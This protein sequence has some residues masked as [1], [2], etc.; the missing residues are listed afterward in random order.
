[1]P[2]RKTRL[3]LVSSLFLLSTACGGGGGADDNRITAAVQ[4]LAVS[5]DG[6]ATVLTFKRAP[7]GLTTA[8]FEAD[9]GQDATLVVQVGRIATVHWSERVTPQH[10]VRVVGRSG[11]RSGYSSVTTTDASVPIFTIPSALQGVGLGND[12]LTVQF[13]GPRVVETL[14]EDPGSWQLEVNGE[15]MDLTGTTFVLD[16][17]S[18]ELTI[19]TGP[20]ANVHAVFELKATGVTSVADVPLAA[21]PV[22]GT[23]TGDTSAPSL[24]SAV[25][26]LAADAYGRSVDFT[27]DEAMDPVFSPLLPNFGGVGPDLATSVTQTS[28]EVFRVT[29]NNP[30]VPGLDVVNLTGLMDAHGNA[31][32]PVSPTVAQGATAANA[33]DPAPTVATVANLGGDLVT[34][35]FEQALDPD[36]ADLEASWVLEVPTGNVL[37]LSGATFT[38]DLLTR[39]LA[40]ELAQDLQTGDTFTFGPSGTP[41][42]DVDGQDFADV[43][44]GFVGGDALPPSIVSVTQNRNVDPTG[45]TLDV[46]FSEDVDI[47]LATFDV[48]G[49]VLNTTTLLAGLET[50]RLTFTTAPVPGDDTLTVLDV[51]DLA[52]TQSVP[53]AGVTITSSD[54]SA[55]QAISSSALAVEGAAND[56]VVV[57][58]DDTLIAAEVTDPDNWVFQSPVG[59]SIDLSTAGMNWN[60]NAKLVRVTLPSGLNLSRGDDYSVQFSGMRDIGGNTITSAVLSGV[61]TGEQNLP[62]VDAVWVESAFTNELHVR[63]S[64]PCSYLDDILGFT[65]YTLRDSLGNLKSVPAVASPHADLMG[66]ELIFGVFVNAGSDT[67]DIRGVTDLAGNVLF[68]VF[69]QPIEV[70]DPLPP[71]FSIGSSTFTTQSGEDNDQIEIVFDRR[72]SSWRLLVPSRYQIEQAGNPLDLDDATFT[73]D[74]AFMVTI[75]LDAP[76]TPALV[77]GATYD[78]TMTSLVSAQG[79]L[80]AGPLGDSLIAAG[81]AV[82][83]ALGAGGARIDP[84]DPNA[85]IVEFDEALLPDDVVTPANYDLNGG[86]LA[87]DAAQLGPRIVWAQFAA[88]VTVVDTLNAGLRDLAGNYGF[89]GQAVGSPD[90]TGPLVVSASGTSVENAGGDRLEVVWNEPVEGASA[91]DAN[92]YSLTNGGNNVALG[93]AVITYTSATDTV[94]FHLP[95]GVELDPALGIQLFVDNVNDVAGNGMAAP[96]NLGGLVSGDMLAPTFDLA[97]VNYRASAF[98]V[99]VDVRFSEDVDEAFVTDPMNWSVGGLQTILSIESVDLGHYR[100]VSDLS[101]TGGETLSI[102]GVSD[103]AGNVAGL[104][105]TQPSQ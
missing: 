79:V 68:P 30:M 45:K 105:T 34:A 6:L 60:A 13:S 52:G 33:F 15:V 73:Y 42:L 98:G 58:F 7:K 5:P 86:P 41:P 64:E 65:E 83:P 87:I 57:T 101:F 24:L 17:P 23:A 56:T 69:D 8:H 72:P 81:D 22:A 25:Q 28:A 104:L 32:A 16:A 94:T 96:A 20:M 12:T 37:D 103:L 50:V 19:T 91:L 77:T 39:T 48:P 100:L 1:M 97:F 88:P 74:G 14:A 18:Q 76:G 21:S 3:L 63:F 71:D 27:F 67:L 54:T 53:V 11:F 82:A 2:T 93:G 92:N 46:L 78:V 44:A 102:T 51:Y 62:Q 55:P 85:V 29:F 35:V 90:T 66:V 4:D 47:A 36:S 31:L 99:A 26:S 70:E 9:G 61:V 43:F 10:R 95:S 84:A 49:F 40:I 75:A 59:N 38:Y 89:V 80:N